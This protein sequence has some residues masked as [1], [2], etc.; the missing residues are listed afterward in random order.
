MPVR[1]P[2][3]QG[4]IAVAQPQQ[5]GKTSGRQAWL[6]T[7][8]RGPREVLK[9]NLSVLPGTA[10][11]PQKPPKASEGR[12]ACGDRGQEGDEDSDSD[13]GRS[14]AP[15]EELHLDRMGPSPMR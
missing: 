15:G 7:V 11:E 12:M 6:G 4:E 8:D 3:P 10:E 9:R 14:T 2:L 1:K 13:S 5:Q